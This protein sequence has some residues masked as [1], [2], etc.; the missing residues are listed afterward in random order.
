V[1]GADYHAWVYSWSNVMFNNLVLP[2]LVKYFYIVFVYGKFIHVCLF[3]V[4]A[5]IVW[6]MCYTRVG[7]NTGRSGM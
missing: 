2:C 3:I 6:R 4:Y 5:M 1:C 7:D